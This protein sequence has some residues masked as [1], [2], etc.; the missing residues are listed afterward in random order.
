MANSTSPLTD[1][2]IRKKAPQ[3]KEYNLSDGGGLQLRIKPTGSKVWLFNYPRPGTKKRTNM[4]LGTYP[5]LTLS[6]ARR[7][8]GELK[9]L[10]EHGID[11]QENRAEQAREEVEASQNTLRHVADKWFKIKVARD[12]LT[13]D[14]AEDLYNSLAN[15]VFPRLGDRPIHKISALEVI[16]VLEPLQKAGKLET[17]RRICQRLNMIMNFAVRKELVAVNKLQTI[18]EDFQSPPPKQHFPNI[19]PQELPK[20]MEDI[21]GASIRPVTR[22]L[23]LWQLHT[24]VRPS[25]A[26]GARWEEIDFRDKVWNI[27]ALRMKKKRDHVVPLSISTLKILKDL[28][29]VSGNR[30][31]IFP[32]DISPR[33]HANNS[34]VNMA[35][36][37]MG[38][39]GRLVAHGFR[40][41]AST[42]LHEQA[43]NS[44]LIETALAH[45]DR[46]TT[47]AAYNHAK[48]L[49]QRR[50]IMQWWSDYLD[51][52][53]STANHGDVIPFAI[54]QP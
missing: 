22:Y 20:L 13:E 29:Q 54:R 7:K 10:L 38:Y 24:M 44:D 41:I 39:K 5:N 17:L 27:P 23:I 31:Y 30:E 2:Q 16:D 18:G 3:P 48:Y 21:A 45:V 1:T 46:N 52:S 25:E 28:Q 49:E 19:E 40:S 15:H 11:P 14:Y 4:K 34:T 50:V 43:F 12:R 6:D 32:S 51:N 36:R 9:A 35:L 42:V 47:R 26:A 53:N 33:K 37:R 8:R